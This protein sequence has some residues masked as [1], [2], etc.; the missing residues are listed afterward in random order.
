MAELHALVVDNSLV[1]CKVLRYLLEA[2]GWAVDTAEDGLAALD[3]IAARRPDLIVTDL[4]MPRID[5]GK[6]C[7]IV[8][9]TPGLRDIFLIVLSGVA[10]EDSDATRDL[11]ADV[12]IAKGTATAMQAHIKAALEKF[13]AGERRGGGVQGGDGLFPREVICELL[14]SKGHRDVVLERMTEGVVELDRDGRV[15]MANAAASGLF[16]LP[17]VEVL[18]QPLGRLLPPEFGQQ[19]DVWIAGLEQGAALVPLEFGYDEPIL[20]R[21]L[22]VTC[23]LLPVAEEETFFVI[24]ILHDATHRKELE[25]HHRRLERELQR[26]QKWEAMSLMACGIA[27]DFNNLLTIISGNLE[28]ARFVSRDTEV[29]R[30]LD[31]SAKALDLST[32]L[33]HKF[34]TFS[35]NYLPRKS[36]VCPH[37]LVEEVLDRELAGTTVDYQ[38]RGSD[39]ELALV[40]DPALIQQVFVNLAR[41]A[42]AAING[43]GLIEITLDRVDGAAEAARTNQ[44]L[45]DR[46]FIRVIFRDSGPGIE[47]GL[48]AHAFDPYFSTKQ[49][50]AQK[51]MGLGLTIVHA[52]VQKHGGLVWLDV[53][54][55][56]GCG[57][58]LYFPLQDEAVLPLAVGAGSPGR[59]VLVMD[60]QELMRLINRKMFEHYD[61]EVSLAETGEQAVARCREQAQAGAPFALVLLDLWVGGI[62]AARRIRDIDPQ[63]VLVALSDDSTNKVMMDPAAHG[64]DAA[65]TKPFSM[66]AVEDLVRRFF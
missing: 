17:E 47:A 1:A 51:G 43:P 16:A 65:L 5:G 58:H 61:C 32:Q 7:A 60:D 14:V 55:N 54:P 29:N 4:I 8:R 21:D 12:C 24:G 56:R 34:T 11:G 42:V 10:I 28:M 46:P 59:R 25:A 64:F 30:L 53:P 49:K 45:A 22:Q 62:E 33:I 20:L 38:V 19:I 27:H 3:C 50:G 2:E 52:I 18:G 9:N 31:E 66:A 6:L 36:Q 48:L 40:L 23:N 63:V 35:D 44:P 26:I 57:V 37:R 15:V 41:N 39:E 13:S